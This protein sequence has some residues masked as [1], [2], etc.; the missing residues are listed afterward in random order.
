MRAIIILG[1][2]IIFCRARM[3]AAASF[4]PGFPTFSDSSRL[5]SEDAIAYDTTLVVSAKEHSTASPLS[6]KSAMTPTSDAT[7]LSS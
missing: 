7:T 4:A 1:E 3:A 5:L 6:E 2:I